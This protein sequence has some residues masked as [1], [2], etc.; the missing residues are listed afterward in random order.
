MFPR[1]AGLI[2]IAGL[3]PQIAA[4]FAVLSGDQLRYFGLAGGYLFAVLIF[5][6]L[7][8][9]WWGI[10]VAARDAPMWVYSVAVLPSLIALASGIPWL[11]GAL[12]PGPSLIIVGIGI[13]FSPTIDRRIAVAC[14]LPLDWLS[15][16]MMLSIVLG[17]I[18]VSLGLLA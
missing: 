16:R 15:L 7:G 5:S 11:V 9:I 17:G 4:L 3:L 2:G 1:S 14:A 12:W 6:F 18:T 13:L 10:A 8:G